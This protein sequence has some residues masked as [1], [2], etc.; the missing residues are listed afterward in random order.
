DPARHRKRTSSSSDRAVPLRT[1]AHP[2]GRDDRRRGRRAARRGT[3]D[4]DGLGEGR[5]HPVK[6]LRARPP[7]HLPRARIVDARRRTHR[8]PRIL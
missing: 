7:L 2:R 3:L 1:A 6:A 8:A 4:G 5:K